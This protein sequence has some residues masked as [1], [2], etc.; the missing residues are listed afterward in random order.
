[1][2]VSNDIKVTAMPL[3]KVPDKNVSS[4][5]PTLP[6]PEPQSWSGWVSSFWQPS[7]SALTA[8]SSSSSSLVPLNSIEIVL[9]PAFS[10]ER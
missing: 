9:P 4:S 10:Q 6:S 2:P 7:S 8:S 3:D 1:M 5:P